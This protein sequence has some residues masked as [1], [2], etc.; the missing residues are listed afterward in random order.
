MRFNYF[1]TIENKYRN[2]LSKNKPLVIRIDGKN[3]TKSWKYDLFHE[4]GFL[5]ITEM[6]ARNMIKYFNKCKIYVALDEI[7]FIFEDPNVFFDRYEDTDALYCS[8]IFLQDFVKIF[9]NYYPEVKFGISIFNIEND[10]INS[11]LKYRKSCCYN[12][13][14]YYYC[15]RNLPKDVYVNK[16]LSDIVKYLKENNLYQQLEDNK[17]FLNGKVIK[18]VP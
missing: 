18:N 16:K 17:L 4:N 14:V 7:N 6:I 11:Y 15:K 5:N 1:K 12:A 13:A 2:Q 3:I 9:W 10:K 8:N